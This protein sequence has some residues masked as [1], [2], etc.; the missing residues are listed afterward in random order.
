MIQEIP[1]AMVRVAMLFTICRIKSVIVCEGGREKF[2]KQ[3]KILYFMLLLFPFW[4]SSPL[5]YLAPVIFVL[6]L[7][8][9]RYLGFFTMEITFQYK[10]LGIAI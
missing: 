1:I 4:L 8:F 3:N 5:A 2:V 9:E 10:K 6:E 7:P